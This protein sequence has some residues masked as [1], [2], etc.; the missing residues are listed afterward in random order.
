MVLSGTII[1]G[2]NEIR[3]RV[4]GSLLMVGGAVII[5]LFT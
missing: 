2:E 4:L 5:L 3:A 1:C